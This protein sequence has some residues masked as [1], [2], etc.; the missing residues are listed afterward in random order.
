MGWLWWVSLIW[1]LLGWN[2]WRLSCLCFGCMGV[3]RWLLRLI[4]GC[5][6]G[7][8]LGKFSVREVLFNGSLV[9]WPND[10][11]IRQLIFW[12]DKVLVKNGLIWNDFDGLRIVVLW[13]AMLIEVL[14]K[15]CFVWLSWL[16]KK[17]W[18]FNVEVNVHRSFVIWPTRD[19]S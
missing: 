5:F 12:G 7:N 13:L 3:V 4:W 10:V 11:G 14:L 1:V 8:L 19:R 2:V 6:G 18:S 17:S 9:C 15:G 16:L